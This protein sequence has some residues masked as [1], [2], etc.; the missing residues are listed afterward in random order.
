ME[1]AT[2]D[3]ELRGE[4]AGD[5]AAWATSRGRIVIAGHTHLPVFYG[6]AKQPA[7]TPEEVA[8]PADDA[9]PI[10]NEARRL[11]RLEWAAAEQERLLL[12]HPLELSTPCY[13]NTG[14]CSFG[15]GDITG[16]EVRDGTI[17]LVR[18]PCDPDT[19]PE[20]LAAMP[21]AEVFSLAGG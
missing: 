7:I 5:M 11:G 1:H 9:N 16:I 21:L 4:H 12:Q 10:E 2:V 15:D 13:F 6:H 20:N 17:R 8:V 14:C 18:W 19:A 3:W